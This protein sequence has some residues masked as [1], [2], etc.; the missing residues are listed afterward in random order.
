MSQKSVK[1]VDLDKRLDEG[2]AVIAALRDHGAKDGVYPMYEKLFSSYL[3]K[4]FD[5]ETVEYHDEDECREC[6]VEK[7]AVTPDGD[8]AFQGT[9]VTTQTGSVMLVSKSGRA[10]E[11]GNK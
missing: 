2:L 8:L 9:P 5:A 1:V 10:L 11:I 4:L 7:L 6:I 3:F